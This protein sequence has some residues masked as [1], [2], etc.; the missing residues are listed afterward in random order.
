M[1]AGIDRLEQ[2]QS[3]GHG[4]D[5]QHC[6]HQAGAESEGQGKAKQ[7]IGQGAFQIRVTKMRP[8]LDR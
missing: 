4:A 6:L 8:H 1:S 5:K 3:A 7:G 2:F